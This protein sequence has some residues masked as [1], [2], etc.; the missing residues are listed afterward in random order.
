MSR[1][2][3]LLGAAGVGGGLYWYFVMS[4][5]SQKSSVNFDKVKTDVENILWNKSYEDQ[6]I[7]PLLV[8]LAWHASGTYDKASNTGGSNGATMRFKKEAGDGANAGLNH[9]RDFLEPIKKNNPGISYAD[10]W[11]YASYVAIENMGGPHIPFSFGRKDAVE[12]KECPPNGR[13]PDASQGRKHIRD[14]FNRMGFNDQEMVA[15]I[16]G[17]HA[18]GRCH[19]TRSGYDG[20]WTF[21][22]LGFGNLFFVE[23]FKEEWVVKDWSGP[24]QFVDKQ[25]GKLMM[26]PTDLEL[27][28]DPEF[29]KWSLKYKDD[30]KQFN[31]DFATS[32]KKLT[33]L[34]CNGLQKL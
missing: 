16:G 13:L 8:R 28:D 2:F 10:L 4:K 24:K 5:A 17:G 33:E 30:E 18:L 20:P 32:F 1:A 15:L 27:R 31:K 29:K 14:V 19:P 22:P 6:H 7:G 9:A 25:T 34:G 21:N 3:Q 26:L 23:L 12:E 11:I